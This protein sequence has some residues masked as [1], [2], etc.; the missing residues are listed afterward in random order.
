LNG[1]RLYIQTFGCQMNVNDSE[2]IVTLLQ[3]AGW[4][5]TDEVSRADLIIVNTCSIREKAVQKVYSQLGRFRMLKESHP[6]LILAMG[7]CLAQQGGQKVF[8]RVPFLDLVFGTH[9]IHRLPGF[10]ERIKRSKSRVTETGF[11]QPVKSLEMMAKPQNG[12]ISAYVTIM[13]GC[14]NYCSYCV[15]PYLRGRE[16][17]RPIEDVVAEIGRLAGYGIKEVTLLGQN[18]NSYGKTGDDGASFSLLLRSIGQVKGIERIRFTTSH[19]KDLSDELMRCFADVEAL[20][21]HIHL[22]VQSGSDGI[23]KR[24]RRGYDRDQYL[25]KVERLRSIRP[26]ISITSDVIVGFPGEGDKD[27]EATIDL[28][29]KVRFDNLFSFKY[30]EREGT[31]AVGLDRKVPEN[32]KRERLQYLQ[33]FQEGHTLERNKALEGRTE[34]ILVEGLSRNSEKDMT[35]RTRSN[36]IVNFR[37]RRDL[38]GETV[39]VLITRA[40]LHSLRGD[41]Q[42]EWKPC[43]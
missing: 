37:G 15:V 13:Q 24:M 3:Q 21:E 19:P 25:E 8:S 11:N 17:S 34:N 27:F 36:R 43:S 6:D 14:N 18:V 35:G 28:M 42:K 40:Y 39:P 2:K 16:E 22:P 32:V 29:K 31:A 33:N 41:I 5:T 1:K 10:I 30:S 26:G 4:E 12:S 9:Q 20:C 38:A 23:L 7:G